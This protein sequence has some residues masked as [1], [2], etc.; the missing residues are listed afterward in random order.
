M[1][2][3]IC[4]WWAHEG[5]CVGCLGHFFDD[6]CVTQEFLDELNEAPILLSS[7]RRAEPPPV[8]DGDDDP[9]RAQADVRR[10]P[11]SRG[12]Y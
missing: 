5:C 6:S 7:R 4:G 10:S 9:S 12:G 3:R 8:D 11:R 2:C 1:W